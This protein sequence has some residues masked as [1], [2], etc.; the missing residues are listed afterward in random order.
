M[1]QVISTG[2]AFAILSSGFRYLIIDDGCRKKSV[3]ALSVSEEKVV[4]F[5]FLKLGLVF[6]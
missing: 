2:P 5:A 6:T 3:V 4:Y 1:P